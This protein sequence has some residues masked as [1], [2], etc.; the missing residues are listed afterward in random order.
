MTEE[1]RFIAVNLL[2]ASALLRNILTLSCTNLGE[3]ESVFFLP[4]EC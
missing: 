1:Y 3:G 2:E 4:T